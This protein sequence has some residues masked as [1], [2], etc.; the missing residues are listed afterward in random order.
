MKTKIDKVII[1]AVPLIL[2]MAVIILELKYSSSIGFEIQK[3]NG[4][5]YINTML[6]MWITLL[7]FLITAASILV[8]L[9]AGTLK[10]TRHYHT[11]MYSFALSCTVLFISLVI[12]TPIMFIEVWNKIVLFVLSGCVVSSL[13]LIGINLYFLFI[14]IFD[15]I[16]NNDNV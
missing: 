7:G 13:T 2:S 10:Q 8:A 12:F 4:L 3:M 5:A 11:V 14:M 1:T 6:S 16:K 15:S 9:D